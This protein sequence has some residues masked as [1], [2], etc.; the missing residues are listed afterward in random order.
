MSAVA[1]DAPSGETL[2]AS[3][4]RVAGAPW[5]FCYLA[6]GVALLVACLGPDRAVLVLT[7]LVNVSFVAFFVR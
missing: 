7:V 6:A 2:T 1:L 5:T 4:A 3:D